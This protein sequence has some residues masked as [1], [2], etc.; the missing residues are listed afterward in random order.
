[1]TTHQAGEV[2]IRDADQILVAP[3][4]D[5]ETSDGIAARWD[6]RVEELDED[7]RV[8]WAAPRCSAVHAWEFSL[9]SLRG[10]TGLLDGRTGTVL[11]IHLRLVLCAKKR[12]QRGS[13][14]RRIEEAQGASIPCR[15]RAHG[16]SK[17]TDCQ[18]RGPERAS[19]WAVAVARRQCL[20]ETVPVNRRLGRPRASR[21]LDV[22][23]MT[24]ARRPFR[25]RD[26]GQSAAATKEMGRA[27]EGGRLEAGGL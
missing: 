11:S 15:P 21:E 3:F 4:E 2:R 6:T 14:T 18:R 1:M 26:V 10:I 8:D 23:E 22:Q 27:C 24:C 9:A 13:D 19:C 7:E 17:N 25:C 16:P 5:E 12:H 20:G